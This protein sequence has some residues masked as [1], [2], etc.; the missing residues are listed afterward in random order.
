MTFHDV[1]QR[2]G[3]I[4]QEAFSL[5]E[6]IGFHSD[7]GLRDSVYPLPDATE[8]AFLRD[9]AEELL[10]SLDWLH[11]ELCYLQKPVIGEYRL[12]RFPN[13]RYGYFDEQGTMRTFCCGKT[14]EIKIPDCFGKQ[15]WVKTRIEHD[16]D[17]YFLWCSRGVALAGLIIRERRNLA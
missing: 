2:L 7:D 9:K 17:D 11:Q 6:D 10:E 16:G 1:F 13:G 14:I 15:R 5:L 12:E 4:D 8:D 3:D